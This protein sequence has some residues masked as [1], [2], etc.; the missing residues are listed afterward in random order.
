MKLIK[1]AAAALL[2]TAGAAAAQETTLSAVVFVPRNTTF[3]EIFVRFVDHVN[4]EGKGLV[5]IELRGGPDAV[6]TFEQGNAHQERRGRH[7]VARADLLHQLLPGMRRAD[8]GA[9]AYAR[10]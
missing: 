5:K 2:F 4:Q 10:S 8:P 3:G 9:A 7:G 6:P 1:G